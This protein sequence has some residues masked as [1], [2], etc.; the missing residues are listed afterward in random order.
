MERSMSVATARTSWS[1]HEPVIESVRS[2]LCDYLRALGIRGE[3]LLSKFATECLQVARRRV[4]PGSGDE[5]LR[6]AIEEAQRRFDA[7]IAHLLG[8]S[9]TRDQHQVAGARAALLM[10]GLASS[11]ELLFEP[12][13]ADPDLIARLKNCAPVATPAEA[14]RPMVPQ[15]LEFFLFRS[16]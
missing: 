14:L 13:E 16:S 12:G 1:E 9:V 5:L 6:R 15:K 4:G 10:C 11:S 2:E 7:A 8:L 3:P